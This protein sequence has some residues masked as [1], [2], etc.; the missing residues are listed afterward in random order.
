MAAYHS[1]V[2]LYIMIKVQ[3]PK[4]HAQKWK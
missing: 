3:L 4:W 1:I 2:V